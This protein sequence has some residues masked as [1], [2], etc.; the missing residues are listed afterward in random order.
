MGVYSHPVN[1]VLE[2]TS[3]YGAI[4]NAKEITRWVF[5]AK[6]NAV[7]PI[8]TV[9]N[10]YFFVATLKDIHKE[11]TTPI[12]DLASDIKT[13]IYLDKLGEKVAAETAEKIKGMSDL[14]E[15]ADKAGGSWSWP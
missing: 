2:S 12:S 5:D 10:N 14:Q 9:N 11:G 8:M 1:N 3:S 15:I 7:S 4:D 6:K 13:A